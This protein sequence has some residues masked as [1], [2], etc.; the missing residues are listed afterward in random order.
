MCLSVFF[1]PN[2]SYFEHQMRGLRW[3]SHKICNLSSTHLIS[4]CRAFIGKFKEIGNKEFQWRYLHNRKYVV[5][6]WLFQNL[7]F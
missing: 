5:R 7:L 6:L 2:L 1:E 3:L 4:D